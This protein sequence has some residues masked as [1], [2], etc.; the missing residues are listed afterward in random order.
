MLRSVH[1]AGNLGSE[2][3]AYVLLRDQRLTQSLVPDAADKDVQIIHFPGT[4]RTFW[5]GNFGTERHPVLRKDQS[6]GSW[7]LGWDSR[8]R[9]D[10]LICLFH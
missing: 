5:S 3:H 7:Y 6:T 8:I 1:W 10:D 9:E 2:Y 4:T